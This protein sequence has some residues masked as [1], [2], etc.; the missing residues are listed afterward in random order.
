[1]VCPP[2][3]PKFN[4]LEVA[5]A[6]S[7]EEMLE[8]PDRVAKASFGALLASEEVAWL[9]KPVRLKGGGPNTDF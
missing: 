3:W 8:L 4:H 7:S 1:M 2:S 6:V 9:P 5:E